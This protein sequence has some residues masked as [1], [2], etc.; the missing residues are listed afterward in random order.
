VHRTYKKDGESITQLNKTETEKSGN[1]R[2]FE[3]VSSVIDKLKDK[4]AGGTPM[5]CG[6]E[7]TDAVHGSPTPPPSADMA[8]IEM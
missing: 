3:L 6:T 8:R 7:V 2:K 1:E 4:L 5:T